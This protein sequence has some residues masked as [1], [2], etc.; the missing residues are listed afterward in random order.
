MLSDQQRKLHQQLGIP[1]DYA[2]ARGL[3]YCD[4][5]SGLIDVGQNLVGRMQ[6]LTPKAAVQWQKMV[7]AAA[8]AG[9]RLMIVSGFRS[10]EYQADLIRRK[11]EN[12]QAIDEILRVNAAPGHSEHHTGTAIDIA[13]PGSRPLTEEFETSEAF[14]WLTTNAAEFGFHMS[15]PADNEWG[16]AY[17]PWHWALKRGPGAL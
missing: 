6:Q 10:F 7:E 5:P 12:G 4:E 11:L 3:P 1:G 14:A 2:S 17:E 8:V 15:Y 16:I 9:V 13:T